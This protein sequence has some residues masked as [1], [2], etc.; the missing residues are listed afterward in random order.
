MDRIDKCLADYRHWCEKLGICTISD[1]NNI[2]QSGK[3]NELINISEIWHEQNISSIAEKI[4]NH[5]AKKKLIFISGPSSSGKTS[6]AN[7]L[8]LHLKVL[9]INAVSLSLDDFY[10]NMEEM[11]RAEDGEYDFESINSIDYNHFNC[12]V[13]SL[14]NGKK[15]I[16]PKFHFGT[17]PKSEYELTLSCDEVIIVE[18]LHGLNP[19]L[20]SNIDNEYKYKIYCSALTALEQDD[21]LKIKSRTNR[22]VRRLIRDYYFRNTSYS[23]TF[24]L[25]PRVEK[26]AQKYVFPYTDEADIIFNSSLLY[27][28]AVYKKHI[29]KLFENVKPNDKDINSILD[30][31]NLVN[32]FCGIDTRLVPGMSLAREFT[33]GSTVIN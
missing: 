9:G 31:L 30:I 24:E 7:R 23:Y 16:L 17:K 10:K 3:T 11:P 27:E 13:E 12:C 25:W 18:G 26:G 5:I 2:I 1:V 32:K 29:N 22:L 33:G 14:I 19:K 8:Q 28:F 21:G 4:K 6:F 20:S 15:T